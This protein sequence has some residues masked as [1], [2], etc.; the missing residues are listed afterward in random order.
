MTAKSASNSAAK[1]SAGKSWRVR[2]EGAGG[3]GYAVSEAQLFEG[4]E[5]G[6]WSE[7]DQVRGP[8]EQTW[9]AVGDHPVAGEFLPPPQLVPPTEEEDPEGDLTPLIDVIFQLIIF[10]MIAATYTVQ[11]TLDLPKNEPAEVGARG[12]AMEQLEKTNVVVRIAADGSISVD[13]S[14]A[15]PNNLVAALQKATSG[16][17]NAEVVLDVDDQAV[18]EAVVQVLDAAGGAQVE[19]VLFVQRVAGP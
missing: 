6:V 17:A 14:P 18:H 12:V 10:F 8:G 15:E 9:I 3:G 1:A 19:K 13:G 2:L 11:K 7:V 4:I 16:K 5:H